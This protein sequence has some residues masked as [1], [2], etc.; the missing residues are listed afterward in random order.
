MAPNISTE[1]T[2]SPSSTLPNP[3]GSFSNAEKL[4]QDH[5]NKGKIEQETRECPSY[6]IT[7]IS[8]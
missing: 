1:R 8:I 4:P 5:L 7:L 6:K 2:Y 3:T